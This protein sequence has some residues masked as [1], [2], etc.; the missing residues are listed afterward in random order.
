VNSLVLNTGSAGGTLA[1]GSSIG[2][3]NTLTV[4]NGGLIF[5]P[6]SGGYTLGAAGTFSAAGTLDFGSAEGVVWTLGISTDVI[7][8][9]ITRSRGLTK[10]GVGTLELAGANPFTGQTSIATGYLLVENSLALENSTVQPGSG[11]IEGGS[12]LVFSS[13]TLTSLGLGT[14]DAFTVGGLTGSGSLSLLD[15]AS[16]PIALSVGG[17]T[18]AITSSYR[19]ALSGA[20]ASIIVIGGGNLTLAGS[21]TYTGGT[22]VQA[23]TAVAGISNGTTAYGAFGPSTD[24]VTL[25]APSGTAN[26]SVLTGGSFTVSNSINVASGSSANTLTLGGNTNTNSSFSGL[27]TLNNAL[28][29][30]QIT[31]TGSNALSITGGIS[32]GASGPQTVSFVGPG[33]INVNTGAIADNALNTIAVINTGGTTTF[34]SSNAYSGGTTVSGGT[35]ADSSA[36]V[37]GAFGSGNVTVSPVGTVLA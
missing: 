24:A 6:T 13:A 12:F 30:S 20:G 27:I 22:T 28:T 7:G 21:N 18:G 25:G 35:L 34:G 10:N 31:T 14:T 4:A 23:G 9:E 1:T 16:T 19:G 17:Q 26:A 8:N 2:T 5:V 3:G 37:A 15:N 29:V 33:N 36:G 32:G 11:G